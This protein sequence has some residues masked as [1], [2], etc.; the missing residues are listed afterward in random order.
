MNSLAPEY[1]GAGSYAITRSDQKTLV[2]LL[3]TC[4]GVCLVDR[5]AGIGGIIH[6]LL[7]APTGPTSPWPPATYAATGLPLFIDELINHTAVA[8]RLEATVAGG[9]LFAPVS[10]LDLDLDIGG[11]TTEVVNGIL[12]RRGIR[13]V[14]SETGGFFGSR[15]SLNA[16][17]WDT[18][19]RP[20]IVPSQAKP[21]QYQQPTAEEIDRAIARTKPIPQVALRIMRLL[22]QE[23]YNFAELAEEVILDQVLG[24]KVLRL[25]NSPVIGARA[26]IDSIEKALLLLGDSLLLEILVTASFDLFLSHDVGGYSLMRGGMY[27]HSLGVART[28][29]VIAKYLGLVDEGTAYTAG[30]L[31][32]I[33]KVILDHYLHDSLPLFYHD[34]L[35]G[36]GDFVKTEQ[37]I[38]GVDHQQIGA[39]LAA[40]WNL[41]AT[42]TEV[43][44]MH[45]C[46]DQATL[47][48]DLVHLVH[49][50]DVLTTW[51]MAGLEL[52]KINTETLTKCLA[53][54]NLTPKHLQVIINMVPW[55][56]MT[57]P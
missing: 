7:P 12:A 47:N 17:T 36:D 15:L 28:A 23:N 40:N 43:V 56:K 39:R 24:A 38:L 20:T 10:R 9:A 21:G 2:A 51:I 18:E 55:N 3:G 50:A 11:R 1:V 6:L 33:G 8:E 42:L 54:L 37:S 16:A 53:S 25:C 52:E 14:K 26:P 29:K 32:D 4:V 13:V 41:P 19:I 31:H 34:I 45:H 27:Q 30:L 5:T 48:P 35:H 46:P 22:R 57:G 44:A 49:L